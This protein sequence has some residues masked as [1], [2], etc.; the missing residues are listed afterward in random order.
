M[1]QWTFLSNH[2]HI[3]FLVCEEPDLRM[4]EIAAKVDITER[5]VQRIIH[6]LVSEGYLTIEKD[7]RR[8]HYI[9]SLAAELRHPLEAGISIGDILAGLRNGRQKTLKNP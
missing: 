6:D 5:A 7:G 1:S 8:N 4:R 3:L 9:P 2:A